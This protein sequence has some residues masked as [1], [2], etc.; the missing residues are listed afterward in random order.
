[1]FY[2]VKDDFVTIRVKAQPKA[3]KSEFCEP[4][5]DDTIKVW[6]KATAVEGAANEELFKFLAKT[7]KVPKSSIIS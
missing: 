5:G 2:K 3:S 4:R 6:I 7:F 1:M